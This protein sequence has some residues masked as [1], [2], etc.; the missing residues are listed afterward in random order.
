MIVIGAGSGWGGRL[1]SRVPRLTEGAHGGLSPG[2]D[3]PAI[4]RAGV[5][6]LQ[7]ED[8]RVSAGVV[9]A[10]RSRTQAQGGAHADTSGSEEVERQRSILVVLEV[11]EREA[12]AAGAVQRVARAVAD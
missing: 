3:P 10:W 7:V 1:C 8:D 6:L 12:S 9:A 4:R 2:P 11:L 5:V